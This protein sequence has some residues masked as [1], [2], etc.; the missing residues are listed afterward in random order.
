M[1]RKLLDAI[2]LLITLAGGAM[3]WQTGREQARLQA[4]I[5]TLTRAAGD[6]SV[7]D[8][9]RIHVL[10][11]ETGEPLHFAWHVYLPANYELVQQVNQASPASISPTRSVPPREFVVRVRIREDARGRL[12]LYEKMETTS[13]RGPFAHPAV[14]KVLHGRF[15]KVLVEQLGRPQ[16]VSAGANERLDFLRLRLPADMEAEFRADLSPGEGA[17]YDAELFRLSFGPAPTSPPPTPPAG[18]SPP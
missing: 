10:A 7:T 4:K 11:L 17:R 16:L 9:S 5:E 1:I 13:T 15:D 18:N 2:L 3:V 12:N 14:A 8:S 6:F